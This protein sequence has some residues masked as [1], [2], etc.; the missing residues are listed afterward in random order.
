MDPDTLPLDL[1]SLQ[2]VRVA[3]LASLLEIDAEEARSALA[4]A[5]GDFVLAIEVIR[6]RVGPPAGRPVVPAAAPRERRYDWEGG[7]SVLTSGFEHQLRGEP[8]ARESDGACELRA[9]RHGAPA[10]DFLPLLCEAA[11]QN[12]QWNLRAGSLLDR[13]QT[14]ASLGDI[15]LQT[16]SSW[17]PS[18]SASVGQLSLPT[19][20]ASI[21]EGAA[22]LADRLMK[23]G[24]SA[25]EIPDDGNCLFR[26]CAAQLYRGAGTIGEYHP[27]VRHR[28]VA[29]MRSNAER[30]SHFFGSSDELLAYLAEMA[31]PSTWGDELVLRAIADSYGVTLH[32]VTSSEENW[33]L[34]YSPASDEPSDDCRPHRHV[35][36]TYLSPIHYNGFEARPLSASDV[37]VHVGT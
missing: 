21:L 10:R 27:V 20:E 22:R 11:R 3:E 35:F 16:S 26:A 13:S 34:F 37:K 12:G 9:L 14:D 29:E 32:V 36:L 2:D 24:L 15:A 18:L 6:D 28:A 7:S 19:R 30:Y 5:S 31:A 33:Y 17:V 4:E 8:P 25:M 1:E 23:L